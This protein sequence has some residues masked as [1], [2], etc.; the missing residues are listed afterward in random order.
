MVATKF[1]SGHDED[2][3]LSDWAEYGN[4]T[5]EQLVQV[6]LEFLS[7]LNWNI[8]VSNEEFFDRVHLLEGILAKRQGLHRGWFTYT[9]MNSL[10]PALTIAKSLMQLTMILAM[11]Y[12]AFVATIVGSVF[13]AS[14]VPG[15]SLH[16]AS[17]STGIASTPKLQKA[18]LIH[19]TL[20]PEADETLLF[21]AHID[22][23]D[24]LHC[25]FD[26]LSDFES[27]NST[28]SSNLEI[29]LLS[30]IVYNQLLNLP[31]RL[32]RKAEVG[33][34]AGVNLRSMNY[35]G[36]LDESNDAPK[37]INMT[38]YELLMDE[39]HQKMNANIPSCNKNEL[40]VVFQ[41]RKLL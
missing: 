40:G 12:A 19:S 2:V 11:G 6:E 13:L 22:L 24:R 8:Y 39:H 32:F 33:L 9:E 7:A 21:D 27:I 28:N 26:R 37:K 18:D 30:Q 35:D 5:H 4:M 16:S 36:N 3:S 25:D 31:M 29:P 38:E 15:T 41:W 23:N 14:Q 17:K 1:Y 20:T 34:R 10:L